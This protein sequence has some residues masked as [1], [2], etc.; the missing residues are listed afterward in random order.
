MAE[1]AASAATLRPPIFRIDL[2]GR[3]RVEGH[4]S[5][6]GRTSP[7]AAIARGEKRTSRLL[8]PVLPRGV[9]GQTVEEQRAGFVC[10]YSLLDEHETKLLE[11][12]PEI[13][14]DGLRPLLL[15]S[16]VSNANPGACGATVP[17]VVQSH[18]WSSIGRRSGLHA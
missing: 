10:G 9:A 3:H 11:H 4:G 5:N 17:Q 13:V 6:R 16:I 15:V 1:P 7:R 14:C 12:E 8:Q 2:L 18:W